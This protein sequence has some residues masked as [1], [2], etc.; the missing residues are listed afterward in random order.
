M[1]EAGEQRKGLP[2]LGV[3]CVLRPCRLTTASCSLLSSNPRTCKFRFGT[4]VPSHKTILRLTCS[5]A[6]EAFALKRRGHSPRTNPTS[7]SRILHL[8]CFSCL[9]MLRPSEPPLQTLRRKGEEAGGRPRLASASPEPVMPA[10]LGPLLVSNP[11]T[12][13][14]RATSHGP[15]FV[16]QPSARWAGQPAGNRPGEL[17]SDLGTCG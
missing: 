13:L 5:Q 1:L 8:P 15:G 9:W 2:P 17:A 11:L 10:V 14:L 12:C 6:P 4:Q 7:S 16:H 3:F